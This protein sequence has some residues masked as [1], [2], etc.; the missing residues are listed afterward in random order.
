MRIVY[1]IGF[2]I[3]KLFFVWF[4]CSSELLTCGPVSKEKASA[5]VPIIARFINSCDAEQ[6]RLASDKCNH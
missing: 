4:D 6:I 1:V 2:L 5:E 3:L